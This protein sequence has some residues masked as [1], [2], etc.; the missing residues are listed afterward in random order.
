MGYHQA[1]SGMPGCHEG[2]RRDMWRD[3]LLRYVGYANEVGES[4]RPVLPRLLIPSYMVSFGY[5]LGDTLD[6]GLTAA[7]NCG[8]KSGCT[9]V[10][11]RAVLDTMLWQ[12]LANIVFPGF[13]INRVVKLASFLTHKYAKHPA[14]CRSIPTAVGLSIIPLIIHPIDRAVDVTLDNTTRTWSHT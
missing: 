6:K 10:V 13:T 7:S 3:S 4:F 14:L 1:P 5:A 11:T 8:D 12:T 2:E 9:S